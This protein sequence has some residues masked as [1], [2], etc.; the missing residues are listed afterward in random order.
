MSKVYLAKEIAEILDCNIDVIRRRLRDGEIK[1]KRTTKRGGWLVTEESFL[2]YTNGI[3]RPITI[4][5]FA[6]MVRKCEKTIRDK[7]ISGQ[8]KGVK[9]GK[10]YVDE[11]EMKKFV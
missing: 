2:E 10:W 7:V 6:K 1:G 9:L 8:L 5:A 3:S 4:T 11:N